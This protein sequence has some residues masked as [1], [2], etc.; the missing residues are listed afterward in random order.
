MFYLALG[1]FKFR[2]KQAQLKTITEKLI[3]PFSE[4]KRIGNH[5]AFFDSG[6]FEESLEL[7]LDLILQKQRTLEDF[8][9]QVKQKKPFFMV[10]GYGEIIG[11]VL[12]ESYILK[13][14]SILPNG[15]SLSQTLNLSLKKYYR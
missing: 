5:P 8:K 9:K 4:I 15:A 7:E 1:E 10:L 3:L 12:V 13:K 2:L 6:K 14:E 11:K